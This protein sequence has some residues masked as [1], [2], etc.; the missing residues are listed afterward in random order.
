[1]ILG[2]LVRYY[3]LLIKNGYDIPRYGFAQTNVSGEI[4]L[5]KDGTVEAVVPLFDEKKKGLFMT[6]PIASPPNRTSSKKAPAFLV[7]NIGYLFGVDKEK[8]KK[9][10][11]GAKKREASVEY[12]H[13][14]IDGIEND[15]DTNWCY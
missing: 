14:I 4:I 11:E 7:D 5:S 2:E 12:H 1:M 15:C 6:T 13:K 9:V 3:D 8:A 10:G